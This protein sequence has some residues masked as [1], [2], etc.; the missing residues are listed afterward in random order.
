MKKNNFNYV[1]V[2]SCHCAI[3]SCHRGNAQNEDKRDF[4]KACREE[5]QIRCSADILYCDAGSDKVV[6]IIP[7]TGRELA[8]I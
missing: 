2:P 5:T 3:V 8:S 1:I 6:T 7:R 4:I